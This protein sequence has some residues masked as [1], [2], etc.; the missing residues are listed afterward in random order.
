LRGVKHA[1]QQRSPGRR[2]VVK[3]HLSVSARLDQ[4]GNAERAQMVRDQVLRTFGDPCQV[5]DAELIG[6]CQ[7]C[8]QSQAGRIAEGTSPLGRGASGRR[9]EPRAPD[10]LCLLEIEAEEIATVIDGHE[11]ILTL[12]DA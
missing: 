12:V 5:A 8:Y 2:E 6:P 9:L 10:R 4:L 7:R 11:N 3:D 1:L